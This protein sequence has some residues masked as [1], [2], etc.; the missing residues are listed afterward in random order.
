MVETG[1]LS[2]T[3]GLS[4]LSQPLRSFLS[5]TCCLLIASNSYAKTAHQ[6]LAYRLGWIADPCANN[7]CEGYYELSPI[8]YLKKILQPIGED[9]VDIR[10]N[11][12]SLSMAGTSTL[13]GAVSVTEL[14][15]SI[16]ADRASI[17]R[18]PTSG[19][20]QY[21]NFCGNVRLQQPGQLVVAEKAHIDWPNKTG[22]L[23]HVL[24]R[25]ILNE[26]TARPTWHMVDDTKLDCQT[27]QSSAWGEAAFIEQTPSGIVELQHA[28]YSTCSPLNTT[29][30]LAGSHIT[31]D[32]KA[33]RGYARHVNLQVKDIPILY[34]PY[35]SFPLNKARK[36][37]FLFPTVGS[38]QASGPNI[39]IPVYWNIAPNYDNTF[40][41]RFFTERGVQ[42]DDWFRY[43]TPINQ[44][45]I[46]GTFLPDDRAFSAFQQQMAVDFAG[47]PALDRLL[48]AS[49]NRTFI[50]WHDTSQFN[51]HWSGHIDYNYVSDDY[52]FQDF[53]NGSVLSL[54]NQLLQQAGITYTDDVWTWGLQFEGYET[55]HP[56][57]Q[58]I[59]NNQYMRLPQ[60]VLSNTYPQ[61]LY[62]LNY[63]FNAEL[64]HFKREKNPGEIL[65]PPEA[66][67][68]N[69]QPQVS[70][71]W[72]RS[73]GYIIPT[74]QLSATQY[75]ISHQHPLTNPTKI[76]RFLPIF[77]VDAGLYFDRMV[78][79]CGKLYRQT[80]EPRLFYLYVPYRNQ[81]DIPIF[82]T[83]IPVFN[84]DQLFR[85]N[86]FTSIDRIGDA[87]Q[88]TA[89]ITT[90][91]LCNSNGDEKANITIGE[92]FY[93]ENRR[94]RLCNG[95]D[96][97][98]VGV[99]I[100]A[101]PP[102][103]PT[104]PIVGQIN[105]FFDPALE[106]QYEFCLGS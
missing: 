48:D 38:S 57:N 74:L 71:P 40:A 49:R 36:T 14:G 93:F 34:I 4:M 24:Y 62:D 58:S 79:W 31:L 80:L 35:I 61:C 67:R 52:Y 7:L 37:G 102:K 77:D 6:D 16:H 90:R 44:G 50:S 39:S 10:A 70:W 72:V 87:D 98:E 89:A 75:D 26:K 60:I 22:Y 88:I 99:G 97:Q 43:L 81:D 104:S 13:S 42:F 30:T 11:Q 8:D 91:F 20:V 55:L 73:E 3:N 46:E 17:T 23:S 32:R 21:V 33:G 12:S 9:I 105:Y 69:V 1:A 86:R 47:N 41:P 101:V 92:I 51:C 106:Y 82:D 15:R 28:T 19:G 66:N 95:F 83:T 2:T 103:D 85:T 54:T 63:Q 27:C 56:V 18:H 59:V 64:V 68:F 84:T 96:C 53:G 100:G 5:L 45:S 78:R 25:I 29:W 65:I 94:V 76:D